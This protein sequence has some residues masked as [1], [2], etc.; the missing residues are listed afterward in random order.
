MLRWFRD[1]TR[2]TA[3]GRDHGLWQDMAYRCLHDGIDVLA[4]QAPDLHEIL[5]QAHDDELP[6]V[7][8]D[9][10]LIPR[11]VGR[12]HRGRQPRLVLKASTTASAATCR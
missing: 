7:S 12:A 4:A 11:S 3:L 6:Y 10:T 5:A 8:L 2:M 9:G 1:N